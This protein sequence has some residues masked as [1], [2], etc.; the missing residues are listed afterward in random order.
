MR[1]VKV[2]HDVVSVELSGDECALLSRSVQ[3]GLETETE[4][5]LLD[6]MS[7]LLSVAARL[8]DRLA[9]EVSPEPLVL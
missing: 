5:R 8:S 6:S 9:D 7:S 3:F 2:C 1:L 4:C